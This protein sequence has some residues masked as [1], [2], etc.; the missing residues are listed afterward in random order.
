MVNKTIKRA[1]IVR[2]SLFLTFLLLSGWLYSQ[3]LSN[4]YSSFPQENGTL[5]FLKT[6]HKFAGPN[7]KT[8]LKF[9]ITYLS[10][11]D[12]ATLNFSYFDNKLQKIEQLT[13]V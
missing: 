5:Y 7:N 12:S 3:R 11:G 6:D 13:F 2:P 9:D 8:T 1:P 10:T 4:Y